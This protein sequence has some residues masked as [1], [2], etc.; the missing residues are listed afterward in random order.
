MKAP[1]SRFS[2][3]GR[4]IAAAVAATFVANTFTVLS[5]HLFQQL[6][7]SWLLGSLSGLVF[8]STALHAWLKPKQKLLQALSN[9]IENFAEQHYSTSIHARGD[10]ELSQLAR[11]QNRLGDILRREHQ[12]IYQRELLLDTVM[13]A[14]PTAIVLCDA[15]SRIVYSNR[16]ARDL[17]HAGKD[18]N[19]HH[20]QQCLSTESAALKQALQQE[21]NGLFTIDDA[22]QNTFHITASRFTLNTQVHRL[23]LIKKLT[24]EISR[25]EV[26]VW[27]KVIRLISHEINNSLAP[28]SSLSHSGLKITTKPNPHTLEKIFNTIG[29]RAEHLNRFIQGYARFAK[30]PAPQY[31]TVKLYPFFNSLQQLSLF[32]TVWHEQIPQAVF[33]PGQIQ[34]ALLNL[35][36]NAHESGSLSDNI[37]INIGLKAKNL[38]ISVED[39]GP[40]M[41]ETQ[42]HSALLPFYST[43]KSGTGLGLALCREIVDAHN[44]HLSIANKSEGGLSVTI[45]LPQP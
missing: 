16:A 39:G 32:K 2:F 34:Q 9:G 8:I 24:Q 25:Q 35:L 5:L 4:V 12:S 28:I 33:D 22:Q 45:N 3:S 44:G 41:N 43:K 17:I 36:K 20:L 29:E 7:L 40:G 37:V 10:D 23:F 15:H 6:W 1:N 18:L 27:K 14:A 42:F 13:Q 30:L 21:K 38:Q 19:G 11:A 26:N 31:Q